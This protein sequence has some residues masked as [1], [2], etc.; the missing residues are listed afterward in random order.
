MA[1]PKVERSE[2][3]P[4]EENHFELLVFLQKF[5]LSVHA[6]KQNE[7]QLFVFSF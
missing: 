6:L 2:A 1:S 3:L 5:A 4:E 7:N